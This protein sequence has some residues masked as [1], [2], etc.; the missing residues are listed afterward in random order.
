MPQRPGLAC[1]EGRGAYGRDECFCTGSGKMILI[2]LFPQNRHPLLVHWEVFQ[3]WEVLFT[4]QS[5]GPFLFTS[6][7]HLLWVGLSF[8]SRILCFSSL[9]ALENTGKVAPTQH[10]AF[11]PCLWVHKRLYGN[12]LSCFRACRQTLGDVCLTQSC[13]TGPSQAE[14]AALH[15]LGILLPSF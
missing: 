11:K 14:L 8:W 15:V 10:A 3:H 1:R 12:S 5:R 4:L 13:F 9:K 7:E 6:H 2:V